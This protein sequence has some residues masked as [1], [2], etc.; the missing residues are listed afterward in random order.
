[1]RPYRCALAL[2]AVCLLAGAD[3]P[4]KELPVV[5][6][7]DFTKGADRWEPTDAKA[8]KIV[9]APDGKMFSQFQQSK[10]TPAVRSPV[11]Y[12]LVK[13]V[14]VG[15]FVLDVKLQSTGKDGPHRDMCLFFGHQDPTHFY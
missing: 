12:A 6:E 11:N 2:A 1:M 13:D 7:D 8:W 10:Y 14:V 15:D 4:A 9:D 5:F 3:K